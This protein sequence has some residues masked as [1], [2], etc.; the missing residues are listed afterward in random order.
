MTLTYLER[1]I[2]L[3][4]VVTGAVHLGTELILHLIG[5]VMLR[6]MA[7]MRARRRERMLYVL[8]LT[9]MLLAIFV[10]GALCIPE[11]LGTETNLGSE[12]INL[13]CIVAGTLVV[14]WYG[15]TAFRGLRIA[16]RTVRFLH[17]CKR[18]GSYNAFIYKSTTVMICPGMSSGVALVGLFRPF[19][20]V[21]ENLIGPSGLKGIALEVVLDHECSHARQLDNW[22]LFL[23]N[24]VPSLRLRVHASKTWMELWQNT[25]EWAADD[26]AVRGDHARPLVLAETLVAV[27]RQA[28]PHPAIVWAT[29]ASGGTDFAV[30]IDRLLMRRPSV[31]VP[32]QWYVLCLLSILALGVLGI[33][34]G[35]VSS[36]HNMPEHVL[37]LR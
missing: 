26:D 31:R 13:I 23:L 11:Y 17:A 6:V 12:K 16:A 9:P 25:A 28:S 29:L 22:K 15:I 18:A 2:C 5:P 3:I 32:R 36:L 33:S 37:H 34:A 4:A 27:A 24:L 35:R 14:L 10:T 21:S 1:L 19:I 20:L 7:P 30:R 8:Q